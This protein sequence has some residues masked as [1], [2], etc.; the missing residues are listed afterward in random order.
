MSPAWAAN[1]E[2]L[3]AKHPRIAWRDVARATDTLTVI[4]ALVPP[5]TVL[6]HQACYLFWRNG[7]S[8]TQAYVLGVLS[9]L[10]FDWYARQMVESHVTVEFM[11]SAPVPRVPAGNP[12]RQR[13]IE[14]AGRLAAVDERYVDWAA[15]VGV[16]VGSV[17][18]KAAKEDLIAELD[19]VVAV[20][21]GLDRADVE[22]IFAT[23]HRGAQGRVLDTVERLAASR[24]R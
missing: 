7:S 5:N 8:A 12:L 13:V 16:P 21:F 23:F 24:R 14:I 19:A 2:T 15:D 1:P 10:P 22:H 3:P 6:V 9:S 4:A 18:N 17:A 20:L 11:R